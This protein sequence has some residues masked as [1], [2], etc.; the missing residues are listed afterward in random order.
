MFRIV[1]ILGPSGS[2]KD[3][4]LAEIK[5]QAKDIGLDVNEVV[6]TTT[7]PKREYESHGQH[8][9]FVTKQEFDKSDSLIGHTW[10]NNWGYAID[11]NNLSKD[12]INIAVLNPKMA[13]EL[14]YEEDIKTCLYY[15]E[16]ED[17]ERLLRQLTREVKPNCTEICRRFLADKSDE[18][19]YNNLTYCSLINDTTE[20]KIHNAKII[21]ETAS[22][23]ARADQNSK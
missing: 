14:L 22:T 13:Y 6:L 12:K 7:R 20:H 18:L 16:V 21:L 23:L 8:Y 11:Y 3:S 10:F 15:L 19:L 17:R 9:W 4:L 2:G 1:G 5:K